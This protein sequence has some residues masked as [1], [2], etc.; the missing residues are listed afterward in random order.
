MPTTTSLSTPKLRICPLSFA[1]CPFL[2]LQPG[3]HPLIDRLLIADMRGVTHQ[4]HPPDPREIVLT[5]DRPWEGTMSG[6]GIVLRDP[7]GKTRLYYRGGGDIDPP[8]VTCVAMSD[9]GITFTRPNTGLYEIRGT[10]ENNVVYTAT[11]PSYGESHNFAPFLDANPA[12][13]DDARW[14]AVALRIDV[15]NNGERQRMLTILAS[16][17]GLNW[18][19]L[20]DKP[21]I[22]TGA[23]D[24]LNLAFF[25][26]AVAQ[27]LCYFR[28]G[29]NGMRSFARAHSPDFMTWTID[30]PL[31]FRPPQ[32][33]Q[34]YTNGVT[35]YPGVPR[36]YI[37]MP[38]RFVPERKSIGDPPREVNGLSDSVLITSRDG[39]AWDRTFR[40]A[41]RRPG[42]D[43]ANWGDAHG[44]NTPIAGISETSPIEWSVYW[45]EGSAT[46]AMPHIR[47][48]VVRP[49][50]FASIH[51]GADAGEFITP[52]LQLP[53][54]V[55]RATLLL[56]FATSARGSVHVALL[57]AESQPIAGYTPGECTELY[58]DELE[59]TV[60]WKGGDSLPVATPFRIRIVCKDADVF[61]FT[62]K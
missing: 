2:L 9:D 57:D 13:P 58:G 43:P 54:G 29:I 12:A 52:P 48:G 42:P 31:D 24:S 40:E 20:S 45:F 3:P 49:H 16:P 22:R 50:G 17:D 18:R 6:Y 61:A 5:M 55:Q 34:W 27:Y 1:I 41:Y 19:H 8:E 47:R 60:T 15:D 25:D 4:L 32:D 21:V 26:P 11:R 39:I 46:G 62:I 35:P 33:E 38:M 7:D 53:D 10:R 56:N 23:F 59:R 30:P 51:A 14:K 37:A 44:N 36:L 28:V